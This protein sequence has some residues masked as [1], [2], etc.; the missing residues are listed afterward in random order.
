MVLTVTIF[1][2]G[3]ISERFGRKSVMALSLFGTAIC[4]QLCAVAPS[5]QLLI[6]CRMMEGVTA[7]GVSAVAMSYLAEEME[8]SGL[9]FAMGIYIGGNALGG[10]LGRLLTGAIADLATWR[11]AMTTMSA[12]G[13][14]AAVVFVLLLPPSRNWRPAKGRGASHHLMMFGL[15][16]RTPMLPLLFAFP[17]FLVAPFTAI[18]NYAGYRLILPPYNLRQATISAVFLVYI[19]GILGSAVFGRAADQFGR[20]RMMVA[21]AGVVAA[22]AL[23]TMASPLAVF[24]AGIAVITFGFFGAHAVASAWVG[25]LGKASRGHAAALYMFSFYLGIAIHGVLGG[26]FWQYLRWKGVVGM[27]LATCACALAL[28]IALLRKERSS[29]SSRET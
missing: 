22:G 1:L 25:R 18:Y 8:P 4:N 20:G 24:I 12:L 23:L 19:F 17:F 16:F 15:L 3:I 21:G 2:G 13:F 5:W 28:A 7:G 14:A 10:M 11:V 27:G 6:A 29:S 26:W 9:G